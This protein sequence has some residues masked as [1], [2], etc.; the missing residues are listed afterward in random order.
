MKALLTKDLYA[1]KE[2][3]TLILLMVAISVAIALWGGIEQA[4]FVMG[5][6]SILAAILVLTVISYDEADNGQAFLFAMPISRKQYVMEKYLFGWITCFSGWILAGILS[7][8]TVLRAGESFSGELRWLPGGVLLGVLLTQAV[9]IP[10]QLKFGGQK[11]KLAMLVVLA[12]AVGGAA[13]LANSGGGQ[14]AEAVFSKMGSYGL[15]ITGA[16][17]LLMGTAVSYCCSLRIM[18][19]KEF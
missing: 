15:V 3:R 14:L 4:G 6:I 19:K 18:G 8:L 5:Y 16:A 12:A 11:G 10:V 9:M 7:A 2:A 1:L 17:L 13:A